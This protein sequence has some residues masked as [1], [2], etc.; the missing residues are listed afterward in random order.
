MTI[1]QK[2]IKLRG[3]TQF[4]PTSREQP[5][6]RSVKSHQNLRAGTETRP[7]K[8]GAESSPPTLKLHF[9]FSI[10]TVKTVPYA[11]NGISM[12]GRGLA[13][14]V[15]L[16]RAPRRG[17]APALPYYNRHFPYQGNHP[18][19]P[20]KLSLQIPIC[21]FKI[22]YKETNDAKSRRRSLLERGIW[23]ITHSAKTKIPKPEF[24]N[25]KDLLLAKPYAERRSFL[26]P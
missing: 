7:Y 10:G 25:Q 20:I 3:R 19:L 5:K 18:A 17:Q 9:Y 8:R 26:I 11:R 6:T 23:K 24:Q 4:A 12:V 14:A 21:N 13:P 15:N 22:L 1:P 2:Y 16:Q